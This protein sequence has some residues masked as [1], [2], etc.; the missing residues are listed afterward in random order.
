MRDQS[1]SVGDERPGHCIRI[2]I[3]AIAVQMLL[4]QP[5][6]ALAEY[7][8]LDPNQVRGW[9]PEE[10]LEIQAWVESLSPP[11]IPMINPGEGACDGHPSPCIRNAD[12]EIEDECIWSD[13]VDLSFRPRWQEGCGTCWL[14]DAIATMEMQYMIDC[15]IHDECDEIPPAER[16]GFCTVTPQWAHLGLTAASHLDLSEQFV[17]ACSDQGFTGTRNPCRGGNVQTLEDFLSEVGVPYEEYTS[18]VLDL[19]NFPGI[20]FDP[21]VSNSYDLHDVQWDNPWRGICP[22]LDRGYA[23]FDPADRSWEPRPLRN[24]RSDIFDMHDWAG[25]QSVP[26]PPHFY[27]IVPDDAGNKWSTLTFDGGYD[28]GGSGLSDPEMLAFRIAEGHAFAAFGWSHSQTIVGYVWTVVDGERKLILIYR[29]SHNERE[30]FGHFYGKEPELELNH[31]D[32]RFDLHVPH[33]DRNDPT[34]FGYTVVMLSNKVEQYNAADPG[35]PLRVWLA[36]DSDGDGIA[37]MDDFCLYEPNT[38][39][40]L[41]TDGDLWPE[42]TATGEIGCDPCPGVFNTTLR[43]DDLDGFGQACDGCPFDASLSPVPDDPACDDLTDLDGICAVCDLCPG[44]W[45]PEQEDNDHDDIGNAC[46]GC[47][48]DA[49]VALFHDDPACDDTDGDRRCAVCDNCPRVTNWFQRDNWDGDGVGD[50]CDGCLDD[51]D[52]SIDATDPAHPDYSRCH[53]FDGDTRCEQLDTAYLIS[54]GKD[55]DLSCDNCCETCSNAVTPPASFCDPTGSYDTFNPDQSDRDDDGVGDMCDNC[56]DTS[57]P[58]QAESEASGDEDGIGNVC[59]NC[60]DTR[61]CDQLD[62]LDDLDGDTIGDGVGDACDICP[63][64]ENT[65][66][67]DADGDTVGDACDNCP[68]VWNPDQRDR[69]D[70]YDGD[71][72]GDGVGDVC[73]N[74]PFQV[75]NGQQDED[76][77]GVGNACDNCTLVPNAD[78][79]D[80]DMPVRPATYFGT[81]MDGDACDPDPCLQSWEVLEVNED[82]EHYV[83]ITFAHPGE[84]DT[85]ISPGGY[86]FPAPWNVHNSYCDCGFELDG[87]PTTYGDCI[88]IG[89]SQHC[90]HTGNEVPDWDIFDEGWHYLYLEEDAGSDRYGTRPRRF[91]PTYGGIEFDCGS[92]SG[93]EWGCQA[94]DADRW[95]SMAGVYNLDSFHWN[96]IEEEGL[97][98]MYAGGDCEVNAQLYFNIEMDGGPD[99]DHDWYWPDGRNFRAST[100]GIHGG[101]IGGFGGGGVAVPVSG[102]LPIDPEIKDWRDHALALKTWEVTSSSDAGAG[103]YE[104]WH[105]DSALRGLTIVDVD[106]RT[107]WLMGGYGNLFDDAQ[108]VVDTLGFAVASDSV[109]GRELPDLWIFGGEDLTGPS[110]SLWHGVPEFSANTGETRYRWT[111]YDPPPGSDLPVDLPVSWPAARTGAA[112]FDDPSQDSLLLWG[113]Q[114]TGMVLSDIWRLDTATVTWTRVQ[115]SGDLPYGITGSAFTQGLL[116]ARAFGW[117]QGG[118]RHVGWLWGGTTAN[119]VPT[120]QLWALDL[121]TGAFV[122]LGMGGETPPAM[123]DVAIAADPASRM[124][125]LYG[126]FDGVQRHNWL[127]AM[128]TVR[129]RSHLV[130]EDCDVG[131]CPYVGSGNVLL[132][133]DAN[134]RKVVLPGAVENVPPEDVTERH[135]VL[136]PS[137]WTRGTDLQPGSVKGDCDGDGASDPWI[138]A[139]CSSH[140]EWWATPGYWECDTLSAS[141]VCDQ[142]PA[143]DA[144]LWSRDVPGLEQIRVRDDGVLFALRRWVL[145]SVDVT[146]TEPVVLDTWQLPGRGRDLELWGTSVVIAAD[147]GLSIVDATDPADLVSFNEIATCGR[148]VAVEISADTAVFATPTGMGHVDLSTNTSGFPDYHAFIVPS[149]WGGWE[150]YSMRDP[151]RCVILS[152]IAES[153]C[154]LLGCPADERRGL[155]IES[156]VASLAGLYKVLLIGLTPSDGYTLLGE[157]GTPGQPSDLRMEDDILYIDTIWSETLAVDIADP[158]APVTLGP[159]DVEQWVDGLYLHGYRAYRRQGE[160]VE[161]A[162][163]W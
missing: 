131:T 5:S 143:F 67:D 94:G 50:A 40:A 115:A 3:S 85:V 137:G 7:P 146:G 6:P 157:V 105:Q 120:S 21:D 81:G 151:S 37:N 154:A 88:D 153:L 149:L 132:T 32:P 145:H 75:N 118:D 79:V 9:S 117:V 11:M 140:P 18:Q 92:G 38:P 8:Y 119:G 93:Y 66:Q 130:L 129:L 41:D 107:G 163:R 54:L 158:Q 161:V 57:N 87:T 48:G 101:S 44:D 111:R 160:S 19:S 49:G 36:D 138:G 27:R 156:G 25:F 46:D 68:D 162:T 142:D 114:N 113:G 10:Y 60:P 155:D 109:Q 1:S 47:R 127:W 90:L 76:K 43:D 55:P 23:E 14:F 97:C 134:H 72:V 121:A 2:A 61:N 99:P 116:D 135:F 56:P 4:L 82:A 33:Y 80:C 70:D 77:D 144:A 71:T 159:H 133:A 24:G 126:G 31:M 58:S 30:L 95:Y 102:R 62:V 103:A 125:Y 150:V 65:S 20:P 29:N 96:W 26:A 64:D 100:D 128:D 89:S 16:A 53:D 152:D 78:Q 84:P 17:S 15:C 106:P 124:L 74:C 104:D 83:D 86:V 110:A 51:P 59:D 69:L 141:R 112:L 91:G 35:S 98:S 42:D 136:R 34:Y 13:F 28:S 139:R 122:A 39:G 63:Y 147:S 148:A 73:D 123:T 45:D 108:S 52:I 12:C 22:A